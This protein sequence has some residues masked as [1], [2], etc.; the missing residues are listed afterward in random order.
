LDLIIR[1]GNVATASAVYRADIGITGGK[2]VRIERGLAGAAASEAG[3]APN[4]AARMEVY[5]AT[6]KY[7]L[8]GAID[9]H[10]HFDMPL[11]TTRVS[12]DFRTGTL[13]AACGGI[14]SIIDF[15]NQVK[16]ESLS[17]TLDD[18]RERAH[19]KAVVDYG[20]HM[21]ITDARD[22]VLDEIPRIRDQGITTL[23]ILMAYKGTLMQDD[24]AIYRILERAVKEGLLVLVHCENGGV[25][26]ARQKQFAAE[27][28]R[29]PVW[30]PRSRPP[31]L[32]GEATGRVIDIAEM[33]GAPVYVVHLTCRQALERVQAA[34]AGGLPVFAETCPQYLVLDESMIDAPGFEGAKFVCSPPLREKSHQAVLWAGLRNGFLS[35]VGSDHA[36][37]NFKGQKELGRENFLLIPNGLPGSETLVPILYSEGVRKG[38]ISLN[39]M[40]A[41]TSTNPAKLFGLFPE[42][43]TLSVGSDADLMILDPEKRVVLGLD[44]LHHR[45]DYSPYEGMEVRG[46]PVATLSRGVFVHRDGE[47]TAPVGHGRFLAR[48]KSAAFD[49]LIERA[50]L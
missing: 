49:G 24:A 29:S 7:V 47:G 3:M 50:G 12:D 37:F 42:K 4:A 45:V 1:N 17:K 33:V 10:T 35:V 26:D 25:I 31:I 27:G 41:L 34:R 23:K 20:F 8:P 19:G 22:E 32:E 21:T 44:T 28:K 38:R 46:V 30:H 39:E 11:P 9:V 6:G 2:I 40:V 18:W 14:T 16:G 48:G 5:D 36:P 43:G 13:A 15:A